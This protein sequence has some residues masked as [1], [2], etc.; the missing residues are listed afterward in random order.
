MCMSVCYFRWRADV[1]VYFGFFFRMCVW[2][3]RGWRVSVMC[4][5]IMERRQCLIRI[6]DIFLKMPT[7]SA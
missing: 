2:N 6:A 5:C 1:S 4:G 7:V 3:V